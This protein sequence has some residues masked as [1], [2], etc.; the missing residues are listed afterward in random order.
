[1]MPYELTSES[2]AG[3]AGIT[4]FASLALTIAGARARDGRG[5]ADGHGVL[6]HD[7]AVRAARLSP[8][9]G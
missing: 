1:M 4:S 2:S 5:G 6:D 8:R 7:R 3:A 9:P